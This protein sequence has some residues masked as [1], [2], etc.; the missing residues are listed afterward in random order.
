M[1]TNLLLITVLLFAISCAKEPSAENNQSGADVEYTSMTFKATAEDVTKVLLQN[2][3]VSL[4]WQASDRIKVFDGVSNDLPAFVP[5]GS[6][7]QVDFYG[8]VVN[9]EGPFYALYPY[10][11]GATFALDAANDNAPTIYAEV[12]ETQYAVA[13]SVPSNAFVAAAISSPDGTLRFKSMID[14][15]RFTLNDDHAADIESITLSGNDGESL[16]GPIKITFDNNGNPVDTYTETMSR[17]VTLVGNFISG[18]DYMFAIREQAFW[19][20]LTLSILYKD[21]ARRYISS[22]YRPLDGSGAHI[23]MTPNLVMNIGA[24]NSSEMKTATP[25]DRYAAYL[26]GYNLEFAGETYNLAKNGLPTLI[27]APEGGSVGITSQIKGEQSGVFFIDSSIGECTLTSHTVVAGD[28]VA[29]VGRYSDQTNAFTPRA[30]LELRGGK[31]VMYDLDIDLQNVKYSNGTRIDYFLIS[32]NTV[33]TDVTQGRHIDAIVIDSCKVRNMWKK[34]IV[35]HKDN[36]TFTFKPQYAGAPAP[37][38][39]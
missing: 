31:F 20:G 21:G 3:R 29:L 11:E 17:T 24:I 19:N 9:S 26:H 38:Q 22:D 27:K 5:S 6:G 18:E 35:Q 8:Q 23:P 13:G 14:Y 12:P 16:S 10:Q 30:Y 28:H 7:A 33:V 4:H 32:G 1:K 2:D 15:I 39:A 36:T 34:L 25:P 37:Y